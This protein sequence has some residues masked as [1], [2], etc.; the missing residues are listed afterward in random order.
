MGKFF[1]ERMTGP[2]V[3]ARHAGDHRTAP[4]PTHT[5]LCF[6]VRPMAAAALPG[7]RGEA[8]LTAPHRP[9]CAPAAAK[10]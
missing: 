4:E 1:G 9:S 2:Y 10:L 3:F 6:P 5:N 8:F 7:P